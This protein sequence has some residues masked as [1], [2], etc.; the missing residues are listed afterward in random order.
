MKQ[1][2]SLL[3]LILACISLVGAGAYVLVAK[4]P[5]SMVSGA[6]TAPI[7][8][9]RGLALGV[10]DNY[11]TDQEQISATVAPGGSVVGTDNNSKDP[12]CA[13]IFFDPGDVGSVAMGTS[14]YTQ[15]FRL[16]LA[17]AERGSNC[18]EDRTEPVWTKWVSSGSSSTQG[19]FPKNRDKV[20]DCLWLYYQTRP[21]PAGLV[22]NDVRVGISVGKGKAVYTPSARDGGGWSEYSQLTKKPKNAKEL[23]LAPAKLYLQAKVTKAR[24]RW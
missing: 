22:I 4:K 20:P 14:I 18:T 24:Q 16:G 11:C 1:K 21:L 7:S 12:D 19:V 5:S 10:I 3:V 2:L 17:T 6:S 23:M 15:D 13:K 9:P 8:A